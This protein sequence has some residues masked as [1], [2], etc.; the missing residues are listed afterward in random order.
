M[1]RQRAILAILLWIL[2]AFA[3]DSGSPADL[4]AAGRV[5]DAI[6]TLSSSITRAPNDAALRHLLCRAHFAV[7]SWDHAISACERAVSL[8]PQSS[9]YHLWLG[10]AYGEKADASNFFVAAGLAGKVRTEFERAVALDPQ[11]AAART[12]LAEFYLEAPGIMG[13]S[14]DKARAQAAYLMKLDPGR[15]HWVY[16]RLAEKAQDNVT[17]E[18]EYRA[19]ID[20]SRGSPTAWFDLAAFYRKTGRLDEME[21]AL[22]RASQAQPDEPEI[23]VDAASTLLRANRALPFA[24]ALLERYLSPNTEH[25]VFAFKA[26]YL[27]GNILEKRGD[28]Q[29]AAREY[30]ASLV[31]A[32]DFGR[33]RA[34]LIRVG[35]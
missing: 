26:H 28:K 7:G 35:G 32:R 17:A 31:L 1:G 8:A 25:Q 4:L 3:A 6:T 34:A 33:A 11:S 16:A 22:H 14:Q 23:L 29:G 20:S 30:R 27:L 2:P 19:S 10:R 12:D 13:G 9:E 18:T 5:D 15:A 21:D 24:A